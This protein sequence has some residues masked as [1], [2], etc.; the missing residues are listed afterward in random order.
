MGRGGVS[1]QEGPSAAAFIH[2]LIAVHSQLFTRE[3]HHEAVPRGNGGRLICKSEAPAAS[4]G[5]A[6]KEASTA[7]V[8]RSLRPQ[9]E[10][11]VESDPSSPSSGTFWQ[12]L[13]TTAVLFVFMTRTLEPLPS[14]SL[15]LHFKTSCDT[16]NDKVT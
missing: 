12:R 8:W 10:E 6:M 3:V 7:C 5:V 14:S 13:S 15:Q 11:Q 1:R 9:V 16:V 4:R 2:L